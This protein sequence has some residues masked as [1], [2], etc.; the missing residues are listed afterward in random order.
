MP[1]LS[2]EVTLYLFHH[3]ILPP[4]LP[5]ESDWKAEYEDA[6]LDTTIEVLHTF[7]GT[8]RTEQPQIAGYVHM[9]RCLLPENSVESTLKDFIL[10]SCSAPIY[11]RP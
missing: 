1:P 5:Q 10:H 11:Y 4:E 3:I 2:L 6:L 9:Y 8:V 7:A